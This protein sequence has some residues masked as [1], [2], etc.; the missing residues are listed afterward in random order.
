[1]A[2]FFESLVKEIV[3]FD[4]QGFKSYRFEK[5]ICELKN[6]DEARAA[7]ACQ[8]QRLLGNLIRDASGVGDFIETAINQTWDVKA[9]KSFAVNGKPIF[10]SE[11]LAEVFVNS[12]IA[13]LKKP[14][15]ENIILSIG[16]LEKTSHEML[17]NK[18]KQ[19]L[20]NSEL[21]RILVVDEFNPVNSKTT[22]E[23]L[24][25]LGH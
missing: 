19:M 15:N 3:E 10:D 12:L 4:R 5:G 9:A 7:I 23:L 21:Q 25:F 14:T 13:E 20:S 2:E 11:K 16:Q 22:Q 8:K 1:M 17:Y 6:I 24:K 18:M